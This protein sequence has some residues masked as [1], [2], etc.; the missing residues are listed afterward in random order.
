ML[1]FGIEQPRCRGIA[2]PLGESG[3]R[4]DPDGTIQRNGQDVAQLD[5]MSGRF[6]ALAIDADMAAFDQRSGTGAG[7][8]NPRMPQPFIETLAFQSGSLATSFTPGH[9]EP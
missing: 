4:H 8:H 7:F 5:A 9:D 1:Q 2:A 6:L 3:D